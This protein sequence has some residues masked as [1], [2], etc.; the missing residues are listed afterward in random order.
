ML[1]MTNKGSH[2]F[3]YIDNVAMRNIREI[4]SVLGT[5]ML[6]ICVHAQHTMAF[7]HDG[8]HAAASTT[9][10]DSIHVPAAASFDI[11][12]NGQQ[13][14]VNISADHVAFDIKVPDTL[15]VAYQEDLV[16]IQN[17][18]LD[19]FETRVDRGDVEIKTKKKRPFVCLATG[20]CPDGRL[21]IDNDTSMTLILKDLRLTSKRG[22]AVYLRQRQKTVIELPEGSSSTLADAT[23]YHPADSIDTSNGCLYARGSLSFA[24][25]GSLQVT[26]NYR[27]AI[28]SGK[29]ITIDGGL[30]QIADAM[31]D[32]IHCDKLHIQGGTIGLNI[33]HDGAKGIKCKEELLITGGHVEGTATG[34][35]TIAK[36]ETT[37]CSLLKSDGSMTIKDGSMALKH[38]GTGGRCVSVDGALLIKGGTMLMELQGDGGTYLAEN[39]DTAYFTPKCI[40]VNGTTLIERGRLDLLATGNG[41]KGIDSSDTLFIGRQSDDFIP[42]DSLLVHVETKG[43]ALI[44]NFFEDYRRGCPKAIKADNDIEIYSGTLH[45]KTYGQGGEGIESKGSLRAYHSTIMADCY[46]DGIN[47]GQRFVCFGAHIYCL[48]HH[49]DGIDSNGK[50]S[51]H[52]GIVAAISEDYMNESF[53]TEGGRLHIYGGQ[54]IGI[55]NNDV[56]VSEQ[57]SVPYYSTKMKINEWGQRLG[58]GISIQS[59]RYL[60]VSD[61][62]NAILSLYHQYANDDTFVTIATPY[63]KQTGSFIISDGD[64]P[65]NP[66]EVFMDGKVLTGGTLT[67]YESL[68]IIKQ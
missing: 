16:T 64:A 42:E 27:H 37:Y 4:L 46:D 49:N 17:T 65:V 5:W 56:L 45:L 19:C 60:T 9:T 34:N 23:D 29:N 57:T 24:G 66:T 18:R 41:G 59:N 31:K 54:I 36:G 15:V 39:G 55:G 13:D 6:C 7:S 11:Y 22:S 44:D 20:Y 48:S 10:I 38:Y 61:G 52:D 33:S 62:A 26:G 67:D 35:V 51:I 28:F 63:F 25:G 2:F 58:D 53:D 21:V 50:C 8:S 40:T 68:F 32:G 14:A 30:V 1:G 47:T 3:V 12:F 43:T